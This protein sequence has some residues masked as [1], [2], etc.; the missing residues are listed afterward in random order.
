MKAYIMLPEY[1]VDFSS[2]ASFVSYFVG[3]GQGPRVI[4]EYYTGLKFDLELL[5][6]PGLDF[7]G[8]FK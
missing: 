6:P 4:S 5:G 7:R 1:I 3:K 2:R 8:L